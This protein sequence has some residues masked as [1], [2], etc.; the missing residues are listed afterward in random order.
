MK[1]RLDI[2]N[3]CIIQAKAILRAKQN[4][5]DLYHQGVMDATEA[6]CSSI[7]PNKKTQNEDMLEHAAVSILSATAN[8]M[9]AARGRGDDYAWGVWDSL[10]AAAQAVSPYGIRGLQDFGGS[11]WQLLN[12]WK[13]HGIK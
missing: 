3:I 1:T 8:S 9:I 11:A 5:S 6:V 12:Y 4:L 13:F 2:A 7:C 10:Y